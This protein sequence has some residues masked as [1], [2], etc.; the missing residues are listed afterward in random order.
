[1]DPDHGVRSSAQRTPDEAALVLRAKEK[2]QTVMGWTEPVA[3]TWLR[4]TAMHR[5]ERLAVFAEVVLKCTARRR[6]LRA[7]RFIRPYPPTA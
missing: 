7:L 3:F 5:R 1:M 2:L 6:R 4:S